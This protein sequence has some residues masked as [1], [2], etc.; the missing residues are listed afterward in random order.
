M[1]WRRTWLLTSASR[2]SLT[3]LG[4]VLPF[5]RRIVRQ[6]GLLVALCL[7]LLPLLAL[8]LLRL[9]LARLHRAL[10]EE[11]GAVLGGVG[12]VEEEVRADLVLE[13]QLPGIGLGRVI[14]PEAAVGHGQ[15]GV[16]LALLVDPPGEVPRGEVGP[17]VVLL[18]LGA[19]ELFPPLLRVFPLRLEQRP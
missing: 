5:L 12:L 2:K 16:L 4:I 17:V 13:P 6:L 3:I 9:D 1:P 7:A 11:P 18:A 15:A 19:G 14:A 10:G 8:K